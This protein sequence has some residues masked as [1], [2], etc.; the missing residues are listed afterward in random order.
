MFSYV[1]TPSPSERMRTVDGRW[2]LASIQP[3]SGLAQHPPMWMCQ[4]S[5]STL[6]L[7]AGG[8]GDLQEHSLYFPVRA[9]C[10]CSAPAL[11]QSPSGSCPCLTF[12]LPGL[13]LMANL[14]KL[15]SL[16]IWGTAR[17]GRTRCCNLRHSKYFQQTLHP[18]GNLAQL[19][20]KG[21][22]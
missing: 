5:V 18:L 22:G 17:S 21:R 10:L 6:A 20:E 15:I 9:Q 3:F 7:L 4:A 19:L 12:N 14:P 1:V 11:T 16:V 2:N 8:H 13:P